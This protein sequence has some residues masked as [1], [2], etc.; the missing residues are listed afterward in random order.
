[1]DGNTMETRRGRPRKDFDPQ[2][3]GALFLSDNS[4]NP[5]IA[6]SYDDF[7]ENDGGDL[8][9]GEVPVWAGGVA[10]YSD[11]GL[12]REL[13]RRGH[14]K[15]VPAAAQINALIK[16]GQLRE[17]LTAR[18]TTG[19]IGAELAAFIGVIRADRVQ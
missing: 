18:D 9:P 10:E 16:C 15:T 1:M 3:T 12:V 19:E 7:M 4:V 17:R 11:E 13:W 8:G 14:D 6:D 2:N 5:D